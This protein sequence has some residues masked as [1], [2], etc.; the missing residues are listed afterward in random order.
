MTA[1]L[2][3]NY[4]D[5]NDLYAMVELMNTAR[6]VEWRS[7][8]PTPLDLYE[9]MEGFDIR[10]N[11]RLWEDSQEQLAAWAF[12]DN[13]HN[14]CFE[15]APWADLNSLETEI[16]AWGMQAMT[17]V[18]QVYIKPVT[19]D[20]SCREEDSQ[21]VTLLNR[22][23]FE[24]Q[25]LCSLNYVRRLDEPIPEARP[26]HG[27]RVRPVR[28]ESEVEAL[29]ALHQAAF[30]TEN[31][32]MDDRLLWMR[33]PGYDP[34]LDLVAVAS[35]NSLAGSCYVFISQEE[36]ARTGRNEG[37]TDPIVVHPEHQRRGV[38]QALLLTGLRL[39]ADRGVV[40]AALGTSSEN[41]AMQRLAAS[42]G[43][44]VE[45]TKVWFSKQVVRADE[46]QFDAPDQND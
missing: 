15:I 31:L 27:Y 28:G 43:F 29:V 5:E 2:R 33:V 26:P 44:R 9:L 8:F 40:Q 6:P 39:L 18:A 23:G 20:A 11:T 41:V 3:R 37:W 38:G 19:L 1:Y 10:K 16:V 4:R 17:E 46:D 12:V 42:V 25:A 7:D 14:L 32:S 36:N 34:A 21:R 22:N 35:D 24:R 30:G 13:Y 45:S